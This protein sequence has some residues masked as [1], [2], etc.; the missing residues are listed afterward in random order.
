MT[1]SGSDQREAGDGDVIA[2][3]LYLAGPRPT[4]P[5]E[6]TARV[7]ARVR[8]RWREEV[9]AQKRGRWFLGSLATAAAVALAVTLAVTRDPRRPPSVPAT[10]PERV[11]RLEVA[12]GTGPRVLPP[13]SGQWSRI[14]IG[15]SV[16]AGST[17]STPAEGRAAL[18]L[19]GGASL[20]M[21]SG[22]RLRL[23]SASEVL[24][25]QGGVY[26]DTG[27][28]H[29]GEAAVEVR[30]PFG[31]ARDLGTQFEV[32]LAP[33][34]LRVRVREGTVVL[35]RGSRAEAA[36]AGAELA[37]DADGGLVRRSVPV[38]GPE[39]D[40][41][42]SVAPGFEVEGRSLEAF[43]SWVSRETGLLLQLQDEEVV[44]AAEEI[45]LHGSIDG[46]TP[47]EGLGAVLPTCGLIHRVDAGT[48]HVERPDAGSSRR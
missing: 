19:D 22:T 10:G 23:A 27:A 48:L 14:G 5:E 34:A 21:D 46:L 11:G 18:R 3:L 42:V 8:A 45:D 30:T 25:E 29:R 4:V 20:R 36:G 32:R 37:V 24:L 12:T 31:N 6:R 1:R 43:L 35:S 9:R 41:V 39:W 26:V 28:V 44:R 17:V 33:R 7:K 40:W 15:G 2:R 16:P 47:I 38:H 13:G